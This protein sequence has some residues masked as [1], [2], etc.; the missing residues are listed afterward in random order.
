[1]TIKLGIIGCG[2]IAQF[3]LKALSES[4]KM[5]VV[6]L[7]DSNKQKAEDKA[8]EFN[9]PKV[10]NSLEEILSDPNIDAVSICLPHNLHCQYTIKSL[11]N[12]KHVFVEKPI[13][14]TLQ[15]ANDMIATA[16]RKQLK[17]TVGHMKR[18]DPNIRKIKQM[19]VNRDIGDVYLIRTKYIAVPFGQNS[20]LFSGHDWGLRHAEAGGGV[21][22]GFGI[23]HVDLIR[24]LIGEI[25]SVSSYVSHK[26]IQEMEDEDSSVTIF[27]F[28]KEAIG[29]MT[30]T[31]AQKIG[32]AEENFEL[33]GTKGL[34]YWD[35]KKQNLVVV[36][37]KLFGDQKRHVITEPISWID[38][39]RLELEHFADCI[40][41]DKQPLV[42][43]ED[44]K[45]ALE[46]VIASY[47]SAKENKSII[48]P[49]KEK[50]NDMI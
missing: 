37:E 13:S 3:H 5:K 2:L 39:F 7:F 18:F 46:L 16:R 32:E 31:L 1:M 49:L 33:Y 44:G 34:I 35:L 43:G 10:C 38:L 11:E 41:N 23:H 24:W 6:A 20:S 21:T 28:T 17:F 48:L 26:T 25:Q 22:I 47:L 42:S 19:I 50:S 15:E 4:E 40:E 29:D 14:L 12:G 30:L 45:K 8:K 9:I 36:S 27:K